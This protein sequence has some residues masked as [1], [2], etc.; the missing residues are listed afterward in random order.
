M[1]KMLLKVKCGKCRL[2]LVEFER[3]LGPEEVIMRSLGG[4]KGLTLIPDKLTLGVAI[5]VCPRCGE[6]TE[7][8]AKYLAKSPPTP[9]VH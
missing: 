4:G 2:R 6:Q 5:A 9:T 7:F 3:G 8:D 1:A